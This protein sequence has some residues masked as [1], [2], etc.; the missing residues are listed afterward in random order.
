MSENAVA[1]ASRT[2]Q[3]GVGSLRAAADSRAPEEQ[4]VAAVSVCES[5]SRQLE[6]L[7]IELV[8]GLVRDGVFTARGYRSPVQAVA[9]LLGCDTAIARRRI[10]VAEDACPGRSLDGRT[11]P[12][13]LPA[14]A[15]V[16]AAGEIGLRHVE[17]ISEALRS[18]AARRLGPQVWAAAEEKLAEQAA[19][20]RPAEL[21][22]FAHDLISVLDQDG[23]GERED[24]PEQVNELHLSMRTG[25]VKGRL[26]G[27]TREALATALDSLCLPRG[28]EDERTA[29]QRRA[30]ALGEIC[31]RVLDSGQLPQCGGERPHLN[32]I[33]P[34]AELEQRART[35][36]LDFGAR[37]QPADLRMLACDARVV[38][39]VFGGAGQPLDV[40]R[41]R[42]TIPDVLR[43]AIAAR[44]RGCAKPGCGRPASW[45]EIHHLEAWEKGG[46]TAVHNCV[47]LCRFHHR[48]L[49]RES[50][51]QV[52]IRN[53][54]PEFVPPKWIDHTQTARRKP[55]HPATFHG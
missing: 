9:D 46:E 28:P 42:R 27:L 6:H 34:L 36:S 35:A 15:A 23:P 33:I 12:A 3:R 10:R 38:P 47:M 13:R 20:Y 40:G 8:A 31:A 16:F 48:L 51:W 30:D 4:R 39:V 2:L 45:C 11:L 55:P 32:V 37:L 41:A 52:H 54:I 53:G 24:E 49:H 44:D 22:V 14:T 25:K 17:V 29:G 26:D 50:G 21:A 1:L 19:S 7:Q 18:P 5:L 43:R